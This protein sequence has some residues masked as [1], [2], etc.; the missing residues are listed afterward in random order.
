[1][2]RALDSLI[3][4]ELSADLFHLLNEEQEACERLTHRGVLYSTVVVH[5]YFLGVRV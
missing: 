1:M 5:L 2:V 3:T 4:Q